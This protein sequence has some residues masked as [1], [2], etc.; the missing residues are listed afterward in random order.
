MRGE[1]MHETLYNYVSRFTLHGLLMPEF[2]QLL[3]PSSLALLLQHLSFHPEL[4]A[5]RPLNPW[6][7]TAAPVVAGHLPPTFPRSTVDGYA[8]RR[9]HVRRQ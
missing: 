5:V 9:R 6:A 2:L 3:P 7:V 1:T 4:E 8:P